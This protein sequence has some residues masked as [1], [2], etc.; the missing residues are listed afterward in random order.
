[1]SCIDRFATFL[2]VQSGSGGI[3]TV[4][5]SG[6]VTNQYSNTGFYQAPVTKSL[7]LVVG[8][9]HA[10]THVPSFAGFF[11]RLFTVSPTY[12]SIHSLLRLAASKLIFPDPKNTLLAL[13]LLYFFRVLERRCGSLKY[14]ST[15]LL[16]WTVGVSL[17]LF[18]SPMLRIP[19]SPGPLP[20]IFPLFVPF[21][22]HVPLVTSASFGPVPV[23]SKT[24]TY[25]LGLQ[26]SL[27]SMSSVLTCVTSLAAG[28]LVHCTSISSWRLPS[29]LGS[30]CKT[31]FSPLQSC[32]P[33][34]GPGLL[35]ATLEIQRTQQAEAIEQQLLRARTR[36]HGP[37]GGRQM[38]LEELWGDQ[39]AAGRP[40]AAAQ[41]VVA[42]PA[43]VATLTDMGFPRDRVEA[44][45][46]Q[47]NNNID[48]AT[49][50]LLM[51]M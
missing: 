50:H 43:L 14:S 22:L 46:R 16:S 13:F 7:M 9:S 34:P 21:F 25:L 26:L 32:A 40:Q 38:R 47:T 33:D 12:D 49:N 1:M 27:S 18:L 10:V 29:F 36:F 3:S 2:T 37:V 41:G 19:V 45:L 23:S 6:S 48:Q 15:L 42:S 51:E 17:E 4:Q 44:A 31:V 35:G 28:V 5:M 30:F 24:L 11:R 39:G 20:L 8:C